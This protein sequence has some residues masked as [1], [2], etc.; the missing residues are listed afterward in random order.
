VVDPSIRFATTSDGARIACLGI[1]EGPAV[2]FASNIFGDAHSYQIP[3]LYARGVTDRLV[4]RGRRVFLHDTRGMGASTRSVHDWSLDARV[5]DLEAAVQLADVQRFALVG[6]DHAAPTALAFAARHPH[7]LSHLVLHSPW[8][9]GSARAALPAARVAMSVPSA[10][11]RAFEIFAQVIAHV[12]T[13]FAQPDHGRRLADSIRRATSA[14]NLAA[15]Y[16]TSAAIDITP[17][18]PRVRVPT[19]VVHEPSFP[20]STAELSR[21]VA[22]AIPGAEFLVLR[23]HALTSGRHEEFAAA[24]DDF[25][26][27]NAGD[28][29]VMVPSASLTRRELDVLRL[30]AAGRSNRGI[31]DALSVSERTIARHITNLY[32]KIGVTG[33]AAATAYAMRHSLA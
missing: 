30:I 20:F 9:A 4:A 21:D 31:A 10:S 17:L 14:A 3:E 24:V 5:R 27:S 2:V 22:S 19:L 18:L 33:K 29:Q 28:S 13:S 25:I 16:S 32:G 23:E 8:A 6:V 26:R 15:F 7:A 1:G 12:V 11:D